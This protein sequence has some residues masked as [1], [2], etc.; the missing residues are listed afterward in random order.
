M[1]HSLLHFLLYYSFGL[2]GFVSR[3]VVKVKHCG[4]ITEIL[5]APLH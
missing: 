1:C 2:F 4:L 5:L 3:L